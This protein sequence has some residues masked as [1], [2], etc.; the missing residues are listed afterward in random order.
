MLGAHCSTAGGIANALHEARR[1]KMDCLQIFTANQRQWTPRSPDAAQREA[2]LA[3]LALMPWN[4]A[5]RGARADPARVI[6]HNSYLIN[7]ASPD[8]TMWRRSI[9]A[10]RS[11]IERCEGL[12]IPLVVTHPGAHLGQPRARCLDKNSLAPSAVMSDDERAGLKRIISAID[13]LHRDLPGYRTVTCLETTVGC[14]TQLGYCFEQLA[15]IASHV[16][17][18]ERVG[19]CLDTCHVTAAGYDMT[20]PRAAADVISRFDDICGH[21]RLRVMHINDSKAGVGSRLDRHA[22]IGAGCCGRSCFAALLNHPAF[23]TVPKV[24]ETP[25]GQDPRGR[26]WD[27]VNLG[28]LRRM[29]HRPGLPGTA[30]NRRGRAD[31][32]PALSL[33]CRR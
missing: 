2:W 20:T 30:D 26:M 31:S 7:L 10:M 4:S 6:S 25:K 15:M 11:E 23:A 28:R 29:L 22:H 21:A 18:P 33:A 17:Q 8:A 32:R 19:F 14:G 12:R 1:L 13:Q 24:L 3:E 16:S 5:E 9:A 27:A